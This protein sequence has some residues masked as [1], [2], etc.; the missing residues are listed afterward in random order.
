[1]DINVNNIATT[2]I[3]NR[4]VIRCYPKQMRSMPQSKLKIQPIQPIKNMNISNNDIFIVIMIITAIITFITSYNL[5]SDINNLAE[6]IFGICIIAMTTITTFCIL[7]FIVYGGLTN[8]VKK[9]TQWRSDSKNEAINN[10]VYGNMHIRNTLNNLYQTINKITNSDEIIANQEI[11]GQII[12]FDEI[13]YNIFKKHNHNDY[14]LDERATQLIKQKAD[15]LINLIENWYYSNNNSAV[16]Q[17][18]NNTVQVDEYV[19][20]YY[21]PK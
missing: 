17:N 4:K 13:V 9:I 5:K 12:S 2:N 7:T 16:I 6:F 14:K 20:Y 21:K 15:E 18:Y 1:M 10:F 8:V 11:I 19:K 3:R